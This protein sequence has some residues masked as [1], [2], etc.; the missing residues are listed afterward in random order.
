MVGNVYRRAPDA[1]WR[2]TGRHVLVAVPHRTEVQV[3]GGGGAAIWRHLARA[4]SAGELADRF[5]DQ[6]NGPTVEALVEHLRV[7]QGL[8][9]LVA[10]QNGAES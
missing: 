3:L 2:D 1:L 9:V 4:A 6:G 10:D 8:D 5:A 7:L